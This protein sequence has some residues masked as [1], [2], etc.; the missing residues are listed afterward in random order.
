MIFEHRTTRS[1]AGALAAVFALAGAASGCISTDSEVL[2]ATEGC[3]ELETGNAKSLEIDAKA[4]E[5]ILASEEVSGSI[6]RVSDDVLTAC[7]G[8]ALDLGAK[9]SWS[10]EKKLKNK[11]SNDADTGACDVA[12]IK[13]DEYQRT[14][15]E[16]G[17]DL[18]VAL[19][20]GECTLDFDAQAACDGECAQN[21]ACEP[22]EFPS[23]CEP[24]SIKSICNGD[25]M[26]GAFC[27]GSAKVAANCAGQCE[28]LCVGK[29]A[30]KCYRED[31]TVTEND[32]N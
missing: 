14:A 30:G 22:G 20:K 3:D 1:Y 11:I 7:A 6:E 4:Q 10:V 24:G 21:T 32:A 17:V 29:C 26:A 18:K 12:I 27:V 13:I 9:D 25:C 16:V 31:G 5:F 28:A 8:I 15:A 19:A 23:R 2:D